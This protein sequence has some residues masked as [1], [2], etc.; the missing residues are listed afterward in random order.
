MQN[1]EEHSPRQSPLSIPGEGEASVPPRDIIYGFLNYF[2]QAVFEI[3][4]QANFRFANDFGLEMFG[5]TREDLAKGISVLDIIIP[6]D[7]EKARARIGQALQGQLPKPNAYTAISKDGRRFPVLV[8]VNP[9]MENGK[10][11]GLVGVLFNVEK[12]QSLQET[13]KDQNSKLMAIIQAIPDIIFILDDEGTYI[14]ILT[15]EEGLLYLPPSELLGKKV[16]DYL[17]A[18]VTEKALGAV[19][20]ALETGLSQMVEYC[21]DIGENRKWFEGRTAA[22]DH[23]GGKPNLVVFA[24]HDITR[25]KEME[26]E[27]VDA[28]N[29]LE[30]KVDK[31]TQELE[32]TNQSLLQE[33]QERMRAENHLDDSEARYRA[34][35]KTAQDII[36][37]VDSEGIFKSLNPAF[38]NILGWDNNEWIGRSLFELI[39]PDDLAKLK[40]RVYNPELIKKSRIGI[41]RLKTLNGE[42]KLIETSSHV[43]EKNGKVEYFI[44]IGRDI[45]DRRR[46][47]EALIKSE[48]MAAVGTLSAGVAHEFNNIHTSIQGFLELA[49]MDKTIPPA[50]KS[51]LE[52]VLKATRRATKVTKNLL[53]FAK[54][55]KGDASP[56][57]LNDI[58]NDVIALLKN[59]YAS[60]GVSLTFNASPIPLCL[61]DSAQI[62]QVV[63]NMIINARHAIMESPEKIIALET[64]QKAG[65]VYFLI[66]DTG[67]GIPKENIHKLFLPF[68]TT[69]G[70]YAKPASP[71]VKVKGSGLGLSICNTIIQNHSGEIDVQSE[72][73]K[74]TTM[75]VWLPVLDYAHTPE[76]QSSV[77]LK[78]PDL[79]GRRILILDDEADVRDL[80]NNVL[81][82]SGCI[83]EESDDGALALEILK[84]K[85]FDIALVDLQMPKMDGDEFIGLISELPLEKRPACIV[86]T[87]RKTEG[88]ENLADIPAH[89]VKT[90][91]KPFDLSELF[92]SLVDAA[93]AR[94]GWGGAGTNE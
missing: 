22:L 66:S 4:L 37:N 34:L 23:F 2:P 19:R 25:R 45:T 94:D 73:D 41:I 63:M 42:Y 65:R 6:E 44:G 62:G 90:I 8:Q 3:D 11:V 83:I 54:P 13:I 70:E 93:E 16:G 9:L 67:C 31:R 17:P 85:F 24:V 18:D 39:H 72:I 43:H 91:M 27:L 15:T 84:S 40:D 61:V 52:R 5:Y 60:Q 79:K 7:H 76:H 21:L 92:S 28:R 51:S 33:I 86:I 81:T 74:G 78:K 69:K 57:N 58:I 87:G 35:F 71:L 64:G 75:T 1:P 89:V 77:K 26:L 38:T 48:R 56:S 14:D 30:M 55:E 82:K 12:Y 46:T 47:E 50:T 20:L 49:L 10:L 88:F 59:E 36:Y 68:Y 32:A 53:A 80:L 29:L